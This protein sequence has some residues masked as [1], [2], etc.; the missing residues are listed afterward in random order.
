MYMLFTVPGFTIEDAFHLNRIVAKRSI[1]FFSVSL[2]RCLSIHETI[3]YATF[4]YDTVEAENGLKT[5][6]KTNLKLLK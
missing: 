5:A 6:L 2:V 3:K 4:C 1:S